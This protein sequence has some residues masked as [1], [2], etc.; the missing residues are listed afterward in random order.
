MGS[1]DPFVYSKHKLW[2]K[3]RPRVESNW[4]FDSRPLKVNNP[5]DFFACKQRATYLW[6]TLNNSYNFTL[7]LTSIGGLHTK[8]WASKVARVPISRISGLPL[9][10]SPRTKWH[11]DAGPVAMHIVYYK[12]E[13]GGFPQIKAV[14]SLMSLC[15][16]V[17]RSCTKIIPIMHWPTC[18]L[19]CAYQYE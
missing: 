17:V 3:E 18:C 14:V 9:S 19:V 16:P 2:P 6:K 11:L 5:H 4:Q 12:K 8:L 15:L 1:H 13:G 7:N 10:G